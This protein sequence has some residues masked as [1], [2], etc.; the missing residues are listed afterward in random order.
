[1]YLVSYCYKFVIMFEFSL[2]N[3]F[4]LALKILKFGINYVFTILNLWRLVLMCIMQLCILSLSLSSSPIASL[5]RVYLQTL[6]QQ[7]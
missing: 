7:T 5:F 4:I 2:E 1:M 6:E 3:F